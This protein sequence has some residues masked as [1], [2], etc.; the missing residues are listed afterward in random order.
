ML[1]FVNVV[2]GVGA[3]FTPLSFRELTRKAVHLYGP[4]IQAS[5]RPV[6]RQFRLFPCMN[7]TCSGQI[8]K[9]WFV[10]QYGSDYQSGC[11]PVEFHLVRK[12]NGPEYCNDKDPIG[13][14]CEYNQLL[15]LNKSVQEPHIIHTNGG[16]G[17]YEVMLSTNNIFKSGD[18]LAV[19]NSLCS[20]TS[21]TLTV[22]YQNGGQYCNTLQKGS[23]LNLS[24]SSSLQPQ[25][26]HLRPVLP[27][28]AIE[29]G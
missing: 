10:S 15:K 22:M 3:A 21:D 8:E 27:Y 13:T 25:Y 23:M 28:I 14:D 19:R 9:L 1:E 11:P 12:Y 26:T 18:I 29:T 20:N 6:P 2:A 24:I 5:N 17:V 7:F 4:P 16:F